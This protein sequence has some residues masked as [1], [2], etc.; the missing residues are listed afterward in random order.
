MVRRERT[1]PG[2]AR[3]L[4]ALL[5]AGDHGAAAAEARRVLADAERGDE[6]RRAARAAL[7]SLRPEPGALAAGLGGV[8]LALAVALWTVLESAR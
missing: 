5:E 6:E 1:R 8:L 7:A 3:R 4:E 2:P